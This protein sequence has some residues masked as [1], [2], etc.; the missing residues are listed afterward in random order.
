VT[1]V[2]RKRAPE[3]A[4]LRSRRRPRRQGGREGGR[5]NRGR[6][7]R[8][9]EIAR[10]RQT[11]GIK[12]GNT[13]SVVRSWELRLTIVGPPS[14][15]SLSSRPTSRHAAPS[16][17]QAPPPTH[18]CTVLSAPLPR[19]AHF[20]R[21]S[22]SG[23]QVTEAGEGKSEGREGGPR[24]RRPRLYDTRHLPLSEHGRFPLLRAPTVPAQDRGGTER[25]KE[26]EGGGGGR[27]GGTSW[28]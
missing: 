5:T 23:H 27:T 15:L 6:R 25:W 17:R 16:D 8:R 21:L 12:R 3:R 22:Q 4:R 7:S 28:R 11:E 1:P 14:P 13:V 2:G 10:E 18:W 24:P 26:A 20:P 9:C 19:S